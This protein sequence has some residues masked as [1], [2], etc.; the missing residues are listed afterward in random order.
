MRYVTYSMLLC[1][2][3]LLSGCGVLRDDV[4]R[5]N[6]KLILNTMEDPAGQVVLQQACRDYLD[7]AEGKGKVRDTAD[8][9]CDAWADRTVGK[10]VLGGGLIGG[11]GGGGIL[12][13]ILLQRKKRNGNTTTTTT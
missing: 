12:L 13:T 7:S 9:S 11:G 5:H 8:D 6:R 1:T 3:M 10:W 4:D 2:V